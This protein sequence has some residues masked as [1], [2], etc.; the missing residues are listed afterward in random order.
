MQTGL[1][2]GVV[3]SALIGVSLGLLG[4][5]GSIITLPILVYV[6]GV[7]PH[8]AVGMSLAVVGATSL[9]A[10]VLHHR[11]GRVDVRVGVL[12]AVAGFATAFFGSRITHL[13]APE[14]LLLAFAAVMIVVGALMLRGRGGA[15]A[16]PHGRSAV[17]AIGAGAGVGLLTGVLGVGGGFLIV[18]ALLFFGG[19]AMREAVGTSLVVIAANCAAGLAGH[20]RYES[21]DLEVTGLVT[22]AA[23]VGSIIGS[24]LSGRVSPVALRKVFAVAIL[25]VAAFL[26]AQNAPL[27]TR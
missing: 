3:L 25:L 5:G 13:L 12:F 24:R 8:E 17:R 21:I 23:V 18:P 10:A 26:I 19:L 16:A 6:I 27:I 14:V 20:L 22:A 7:P 15:Q 4:G 1:A 2:I 9:V 11:E